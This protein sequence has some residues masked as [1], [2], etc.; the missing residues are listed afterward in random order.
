MGGGARRALGPRLP[1]TPVLSHSL[2][3]SKAPCN[4]SHLDSPRHGPLRFAKR[5]EARGSPAR[6]RRAGDPPLRTSSP[7]SGSRASSHLV[8]DNAGRGGWSA[9]SAASARLPGMAKLVRG[10]L[11]MLSG[12]AAIQSANFSSFFPWDEAIVRVGVPRAGLRTPGQAG[13]PLPLIQCLL[14]PRWSLHSA[15]RHTHR[16][17]QTHAN[18]NNYSKHPVLP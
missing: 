13:R 14:R 11:W 3:A 10:M 9:P 7:P 6:A 4:S 18:F 5:Q 8:A 17:A 1:P 12:R 15:L 16:M 2:S